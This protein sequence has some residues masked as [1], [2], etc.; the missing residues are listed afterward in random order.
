M[1]PAELFYLWFGFVCG[2]SL[3]TFAGYVFFKE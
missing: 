1:T 3:G 2:L